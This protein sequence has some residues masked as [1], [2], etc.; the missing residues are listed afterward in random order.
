DVLVNNAGHGVSAF[1]EEL[2]Q[3]ELEHVFRVNVYAPVQAAQLALPHLER[4]GG[5]VIN[6]GSVIGR[7]AVP[8][9]GAYCMTKFPLAALSESLRAEVARHGVHVL[10]VEPGLTATGFGDHRVMIGDHPR[11]YRK[12]FVMSAETAARRIVAAAARRR[13]RVVLTLAGR[14]LILANTVAPRL[15]N[16]LLA[17]NIRDRY[18]GAGGPATRQS[19]A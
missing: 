17:R 12:S 2:P 11:S 10:H 3:A 19:P 1:L 15:L 9:L 5:Q 8:V 6:V 14:L 13:D 16:R 7:R 18:G 4:A